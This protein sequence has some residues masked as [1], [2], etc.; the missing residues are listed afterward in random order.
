M[1]NTWSDKQKTKVTRASMATNK[2]EHKRSDFN[3]L[4]DL[5]QDQSYHVNLIYSCFTIFFTLG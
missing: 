3:M 4:T 2:L 1:T 5:D